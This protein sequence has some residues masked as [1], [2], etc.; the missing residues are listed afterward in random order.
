MTDFLTVTRNKHLSPDRCNLNVE[1]VH[2]LRGELH[3]NRADASVVARTNSPLGGQRLYAG[4]GTIQPSFCLCTCTPEY[5]YYC[6]EDDPQCPC[7]VHMHNTYV[8]AG[9]CLLR[10]VDVFSDCS[11]D[12]RFRDL[13]YKLKLTCSPGR[14]YRHWVP[15]AENGS[16]RLSPAL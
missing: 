11:G 16:L 5:M 13:W 12:C 4:R 7:T 2:A 10:G 14:Q 9:R 15:F 8:G 1:Q 3:A 6:M